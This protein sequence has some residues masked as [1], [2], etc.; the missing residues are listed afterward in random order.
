VTEQFRVSAVRAPDMDDAEARRRLSRAY[1]I[2][3][4]TDRRT[5]A[6]KTADQ[7]EFGDLIRTLLEATAPDEAV[8]S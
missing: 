1:T 5:K 4:E 2:I 7:G 3:I 8:P 6:Q